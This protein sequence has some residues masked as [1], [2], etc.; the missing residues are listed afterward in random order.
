[1][2]V[3]QVD[4]LLEWSLLNVTVITPNA[5][6]TR[7]S[8]GHSIKPVTTITTYLPTWRPLWGPISFATARRH[9]IDREY[10]NLSKTITFW[11][12]FN[13]HS[14]V[15]TPEWVWL[16]IIFFCKYLFSHLLQLNLRLFKLFELDFVFS[17][18]YLQSLQL[19]VQVLDLFLQP[20]NLL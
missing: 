4:I 9:R 20:F 15:M 5:T 8:G 3:F 12:F 7:F 18:F 1:M 17:S 6:S 16:D 13:W 19:L 14:R 10:H 11:L 2:A